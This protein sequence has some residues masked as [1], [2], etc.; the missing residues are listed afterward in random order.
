MEWTA[1]L[2]ACL[3]LGQLSIGEVPASFNPAARYADQTAAE[4]APASTAQTPPAQAPAT[5]PSPAEPGLFSPQPGVA[6]SNWQPVPPA[7]TSQS[8]PAEAQAATAEAETSAPANT[9]RSLVPV[10]PE[11]AEPAAARLLREGLAPPEQDALQGRTIYLPDL[12]SPGR[13]LSPATRDA[14]GAY[15]RLAVALGDYHFALGEHEQ[16]VQTLGSR[17]DREPALAAAVASAFAR[18]QTARLAAVEAQH[19]L[20]AQ[21]MLP[22]NDD[23]PLPGDRPLVVPYQTFYDQLF[24]QGATATPR[25]RQ[26]RRIHDTLPLRL[27]ALNAQAAAAA[28]S[29]KLLEQIAS[30]LAAGRG[31]EAM[32]LD[33]HDKLRQQRRAFLDAVLHYNLAITDYALM[34]A[35]DGA[36]A[37]SLLPML[38]ENPPALTAPAPAAEPRQATSAGPTPAVAGIPDGSAVVP[39]T[40]EAPLAAAPPQQSTPTAPRTLRSVV[41][42]SRR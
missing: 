34:V 21:L 25:R 11:G 6:D 5:K 38:M 23:L 29:E 41:V 17:T 35:P 42:P 19:E 40:A 26:A 4:P 8:V 13:L 27:Q 12:L 33:R 3:L 20:A 22:T 9:P 7:T 36:V 39:A 30:A 18:V 2:L 32:Y 28:A 1:A 15:W 24:A 14:L 16:L 37:A 10:H 31:S